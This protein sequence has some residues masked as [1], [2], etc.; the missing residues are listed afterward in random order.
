MGDFACWDP[1]GVTFE[2]T[3]RS[4]NFSGAAEFIGFDNITLASEVPV[5]EPGTVLLAGASVLA[6]ARRRLVQS[7]RA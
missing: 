2:G 7:A 6:L 5:P 4:V 3:A 1:I